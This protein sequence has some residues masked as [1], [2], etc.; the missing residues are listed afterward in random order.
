MISVEA[1]IYDIDLK[2][3]KVATNEHQQIP[4]EDKIIALNEAQIQL[5]KQKFSENN[6]YKAGIDAFKKRYDDLQFLVTKSSINL[7]PSKTVINQYSGNLLNMNP[8]YMF[9][10]D[11]F[12]LAK[13]GQCSDRI[14]HALLIK[15]SDVWIY[16]NNTN[17]SPSFEYQET[18]CT[19][20]NNNYE[21]YTD[22]TFTPTK[23][24]ISY[25]R[26][27]KYIDYIGYENFDG[28]PSITTDCELPDYLRD[29]LVDL[30]VQKL[31]MS[32]EN[33]IAAQYSTQRLAND[34]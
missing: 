18:L 22:G 7:S 2:L 31:A 6:I 19:L 32:T 21:V 23:V 29:E 1:L 25:I 20:S 4:L 5:I 17:T 24:E 13:K 10:V 3:N 12:I 16:I 15:H 27:P 34:E 9:Y 11:G 14:L 28:S 8:K 33:N 26:Y 30:T